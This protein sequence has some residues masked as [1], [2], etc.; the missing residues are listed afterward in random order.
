MMLLIFRIQ[1]DILYGRGPCSPNH[2][3]FRGQVFNLSLQDEFLS[4]EI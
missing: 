1:T 2:I 4:L 3:T